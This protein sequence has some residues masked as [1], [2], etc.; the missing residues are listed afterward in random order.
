[1]SNQQGNGDKEGC[2]IATCVY[3]SY[4]CPNVWV[5]RRFRDETLRKTFLG[6]QLI[7]IYYALSPGLVKRFGR[8]QLFLDFWKAALDFLVYRLKENG[9][10]DSFYSDPR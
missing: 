7:N 1:M 3:G 4:D 9:F 10:N 6:N 8:S 5:L 2:F